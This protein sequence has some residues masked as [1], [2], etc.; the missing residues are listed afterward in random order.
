MYS[1]R[2][3]DIKMIHQFCGFVEFTLDE[4]LK[5]VLKLC[6]WERNE[7]YIY[8]DGDFKTDP[9]D[10]LKADSVVIPIQFRHEYTFLQS[11]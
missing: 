2:I 1:Y 8:D 9:W 7:W 11:S 6:T 10:V 4:E 3:W 5:V